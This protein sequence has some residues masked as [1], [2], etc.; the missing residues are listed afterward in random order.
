M[1]S[2]TKQTSANDF[3]LSAAQK[4]VLLALYAGSKPYANQGRTAR[5]LVRRLMVA[6]VARGYQL[7]ATGRYVAGELLRES[8]SH[9]GVKK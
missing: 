2:N 1:A 3:P 9:E 5:S 8:S 4:G 7:T 6:D